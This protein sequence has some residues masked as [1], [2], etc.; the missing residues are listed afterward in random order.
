MT[1]VQGQSTKQTT[2]K[3]KKKNICVARLPARRKAAANSLFGA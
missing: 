3:Y 2:T 1:H